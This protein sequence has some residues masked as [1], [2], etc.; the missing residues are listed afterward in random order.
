MKHYN[1]EAQIYQESEK[2]E[3]LQSFHPG[4]GSSFCKL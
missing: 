2:A 1:N 3:P 4:D